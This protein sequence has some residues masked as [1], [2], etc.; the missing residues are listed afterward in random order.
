ML[1]AFHEIFPIFIIA[2]TSQRNNFSCLEKKEEKKDVKEKLIWNSIE[3]CR[4]MHVDLLV[5]E[6]KLAGKYK[7][8]HTF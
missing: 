7:G 4:E 6:L 5:M 8:T 1:D 3:E 2:Q